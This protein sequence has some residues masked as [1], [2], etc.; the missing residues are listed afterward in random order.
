MNV[1][2]EEVE[3]FVA[4]GGDGAVCVCG[5]AWLEGP[6]WGRWKD[7]FPR[8]KGAQEVDRFRCRLGKECIGAD[9]PSR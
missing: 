6:S 4:D 7:L 9:Q 2:L 8:R 1:E 5:F 3:E